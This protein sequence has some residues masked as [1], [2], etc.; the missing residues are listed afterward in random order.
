METTGKHI[1]D[2]IASTDVFTLAT[3]H[4]GKPYCTPCFYA[5]DPTEKLLVFKS[6]V[7]TRHVTELLLQ[8]QIAGSILPKTPTIGKVKGVQFSGEALPLEEV[9]NSNRLKQLYYK[10]F[11]MALPMVGE[12]WVIAL[13]NI[14]MTD[15]TLGFGKKLR[16][17][18][19]EEV[20]ANLN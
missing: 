10:S 16:W 13:S 11:P 7:G 15:N 2:F 8:P 14:K 17:E 19:T 9:K 4:R 12:L 5:F 20:S 1:W 18:R 3:C 6:E